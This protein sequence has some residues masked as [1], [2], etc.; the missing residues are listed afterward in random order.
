[1]RCGS[2][3]DQ[4]LKKVYL[5]EDDLIL[6][7]VQA[8]VKARK[9]KSGVRK[10]SSQKDTS[11]K[12]HV[13]IH[14]Q[15]KSEPVLV[16]S[17]EDAWASGAELAKGKAKT[18]LHHSSNENA[19]TSHSV[20]HLVKSGKI[21][22]SRGA[23]HFAGGVPLY[24]SSGGKSVLVGSLG[25]AGD[26]PEVDEAIAL[27]A[28]KGFEAPKHIRSD[29]VLAIPFETE[30]PVEDLAVEIKSGSL[31]KLPPLPSSAMDKL[32]ALPKSPL[33]SSK[34]SL[35]SSRRSSPRSSR[36]SPA[37]PKLAKSSPRKSPLPKLPPSPSL[38]PSV[39]S[40]LPS[41]P[42]LSSSSLPKVPKLASPKLASPKL[43]PISKLTPLK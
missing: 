34:S 4:E 24:K 15:G 1:M 28:S 18:S 16:H 9:V 22:S 43:P 13:A 7:L 19:M 27:A 42:S 2:S 11:P 36:A 17:D 20:G 30:S 25:V 6:V 10:D 8:L 38:S 37:L 21:P 35:K 39:K 40:S 14:G 29:K 31:D 33:K 3:S 5:T 23:V 32:P 12:I 26:L 41:L